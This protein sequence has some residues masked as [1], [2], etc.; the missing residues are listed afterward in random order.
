MLAIAHRGASAYA[1]ENTRAAFALALEL[2]ADLIET[3]IQLTR[4]NSLVLMHDD[5]VDR[6]S[7]G[8]GPVADYTLAELRQL[9]IG[10]WFGQAFAG[11]RVLTLDEWVAEFGRAMPLCLEIKNPLATQPTLD[12]LAAHGIPRGLQVTSFSWLAATRAAAA[13][14]CP[15]GFLT[16]VYDLDIIERCAARGLA[17]VCPLVSTL[18]PGLVEAAHQ[19]GLMVRAWGIK[20]REDVDLA[21][22]T[23]ADGATSNWPDWITDHPGYRKEPRA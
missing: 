14:D 6:T 19:R 7:D 16:P 9:D 8:V 1:P 18:T 5:R 20:T 2:R 11:E 22:A 23:G 15:C 12:W 21:Y 4:D 10:G 3:D 13:L 17:Q